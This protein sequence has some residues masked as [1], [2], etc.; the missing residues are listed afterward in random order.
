MPI[1]G[2]P[3][4]PYTNASLEATELGAFVSVAF[5]IQSNYII[6]TRAIP[7]KA[8]W[9]RSFSPEERAYAV[10]LL[11]KYYGFGR[12]TGETVTAEDQSHFW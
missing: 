6:A 10:K 11:E 7:L 5:S 9:M 3:V 1:L 12:C 2:K 8:S 4:P